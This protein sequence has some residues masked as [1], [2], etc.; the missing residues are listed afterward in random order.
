MCVNLE[1]YLGW[2][3]G[4]SGYGWGERWCGFVFRRQEELLDFPVEQLF[5]VG[6]F[7]CYGANIALAIEFRNLPFVLDATKH[8]VCCGAAGVWLWQA[9]AAIAG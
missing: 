2:R 3:V 9:P 6:V 1:S 4:S 8:L 7:A 5:L